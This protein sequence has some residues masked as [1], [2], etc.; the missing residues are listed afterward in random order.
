MLRGVQTHHDHESSIAH[1][2][3][4]C[5]KKRFQEARNKDKFRYPSAKSV[6]SLFSTLRAVDLDKQQRKPSLP[7]NFNQ[8]EWISV[9]ELKW[10]TVMGK[11]IN[12]R[13]NALLHW[14]RHCSVN[15]TFSTCKIPA[16]PLWLSPL[17]FCTEHPFLVGLKWKQGKRDMHHQ[18]Q[19]IWSSTTELVVLDKAQQ[20][21]I[22]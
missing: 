15:V 2:N 1:M 5:E 9:R 4:V 6:L 17:V 16:Q 10:L 12:A 22:N 19:V 7:R 3:A 14:L 21:I 18:M 13:V 11:I 20:K 8:A